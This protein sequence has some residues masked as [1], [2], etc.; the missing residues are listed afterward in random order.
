MPKQPTIA[1]YLAQIE[2]TQSYGDRLACELLRDYQRRIAELDTLIADAGD[3]AP[4][5][6]IL[7]NERRGLVFVAE[8]IGMIAV[9]YREPPE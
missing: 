6:A 3:D 9:A 1:D 2:P 7:K 8:S 4:R 5:L